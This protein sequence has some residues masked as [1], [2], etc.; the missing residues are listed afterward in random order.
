MLEDFADVQLRTTRETK[1]SRS[2][3][4]INEEYMSK[5]VPSRKHESNARTDLQEAEEGDRLHAVLTATISRAG[6]SRPFPPFPTI[7]HSGFFHR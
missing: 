5:F 7:S 6:F 1:A 3:T 4:G 2:C